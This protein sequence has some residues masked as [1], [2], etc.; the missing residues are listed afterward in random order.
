MH[1]PQTVQYAL[2]ALQHIASR[3]PELVQAGELTAFVGA[4][5]NYLSKTLHQLVRGGILMSSRG[6]A[7][8]FTLAVPAATVT[9]ERVVSV[10]A[11]P[12]AG[13]CLF[14]GGRC[15]GDDRCALHA[16]W[17]VVAQPMDA[18]FR[19]TTIAD[20]LADARPSTGSWQRQSTSS[21]TRGV[22]Q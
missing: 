8:G 14:G 9:L 21:S 18:F 19:T 10:F 16:R 7:G 17:R 15:G 1:L 12:D 6:P 5:A 22:A 20:L 3:A 13:L 2:R 11:T 4:R